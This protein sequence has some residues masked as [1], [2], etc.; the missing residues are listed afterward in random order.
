MKISIKI[1]KISFEVFLVGVESSNEFVWVEYILDFEKPCKNK[2]K[3]GNYGN[4]GGLST[5]PLHPINKRSRMIVVYK[6]FHLTLGVRKRVLPRGD[7][8]FVRKTGVKNKF[9]L[10]C[11]GLLINPANCNFMSK[12]SSLSSCNKFF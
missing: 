1:I 11:F 7:Q 2:P 10:L 4:C 5:A 12:L 3:G 6:P 9:V 8:K